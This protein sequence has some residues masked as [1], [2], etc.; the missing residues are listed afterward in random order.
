MKPSEYFARNVMIGASCMPRR[1]AE[2]RHEIGLGNIAWGSDYPHPEGSWPHTAD[3]MKDTFMDLPEKDI[4]RMLGQNA[5]DFW[6]FD[7]EKLAPIVARIGPE[8]SI[9]RS[10]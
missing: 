9:F 8:K 5:V 6:G 3:Q 10:S 2:L 4:A 7:A 1:E